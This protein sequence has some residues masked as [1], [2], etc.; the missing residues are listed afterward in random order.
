M[1]SSLN[2]YYNQ[3]ENVL[4]IVFSSQNELL[5]NIKIHE[6]LGNSVHNQ[7]HVDIKIKSESINK[8]YRRNFHKGKYKYMRKYLANLDWNNMLRNKIAIECWNI[9]NYEIESIIDKCV[10]LKKQGKTI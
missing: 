8:K 1:A 10:P 6:P 9:L 5:D 4:Y 2:K 3:P 7:I